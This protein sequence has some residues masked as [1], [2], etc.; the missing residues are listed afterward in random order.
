VRLVAEMRARLE[1]LT[2]GEIWQSHGAYPC[3]VEPRRIMSSEA[4]LATGAAP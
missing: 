1:Q 3:P 2:H 4:S